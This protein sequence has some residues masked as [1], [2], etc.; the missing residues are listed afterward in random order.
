[1]TNVCRDNYENI[2]QIDTLIKS[3]QKPLGKPEVSVRESGSFG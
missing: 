2:L 3:P 1:M